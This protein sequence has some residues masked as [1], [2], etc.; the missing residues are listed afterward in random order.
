WVMAHMDVVPIGEASL[1]QTDP[2]TVVEKD[3]KIFGRGVEDN[4]QGLVSGVFAALSF[5]KNNITPAH[6]VKL[7]FISDEEVGSKYGIQYLLDNHKLFKKEDIIVIPDGGDSKGET[8]E[9][10]EKNIL[11]L[12]IKVSGKQAHGSQPNNG[13]NACLAACDLSLR[14]HNLENV[15]D[16]KDELFEP[17]YSTFSPTMRDANVGS[18]NIIPGEDVFCMDCRVLPCYSLKEVLEKLDELCRSVEVEHGVKI[19]YEKVQAEESPATPVDSPVVKKLSS[20]LKKT[21]N[22]TPRIIGIGGGTVGA[23]LRKSGYDAVVWST[24]DEM[25]HQVNE[26]CVVKNMIEDAKTLA[27]LFLE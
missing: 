7:L 1:W 8:I 14:L 15:F 11:W 23:Y 6:T 19:S 9:V 10:A 2:W 26:Y 21:R 16:K 20:A 25:M 17:N 18:I 22:I 3:G 27:A 13:A 12:R 4:Q 24:L 5:L